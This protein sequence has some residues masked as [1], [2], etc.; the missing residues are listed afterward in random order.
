MVVEGELEGSL[1]VRLRRARADRLEAP[2]QLVAEPAKP[3]AGDRPR[4][5]PERRLS[6][7]QRER[8]IVV[9]RY[10]DRL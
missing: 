8:V 9:R 5:R 10:L 3:A 1:G 7:E 4:T 2:G 6:V